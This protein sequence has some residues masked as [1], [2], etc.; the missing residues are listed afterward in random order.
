MIAQIFVAAARF[1]PRSSG[2]SK[3][4]QSFVIAIGTGSIGRLMGSGGAS[5]EIKE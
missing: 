4:F 5:N 1:T 2:I 3:V